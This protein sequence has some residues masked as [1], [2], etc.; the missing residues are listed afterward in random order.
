[1]ASDINTYIK[2]ERSIG[3]EFIGL[4]AALLMDE[5]TVEEESM[6]HLVGN[7]ILPLIDYFLEEAKETYFREDPLTFRKIVEDCI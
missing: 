5:T 4:A 3:E 1:M 6:T 2:N 7:I